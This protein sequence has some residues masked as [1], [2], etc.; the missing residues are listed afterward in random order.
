MSEHLHKRRVRAVTTTCRPWEAFSL[1]SISH[2]TC[3]AW[4]LRSIS[5]RPPALQ[6]SGRELVNR[7]LWRGEMADVD[8]W[9]SETKCRR[10]EESAVSL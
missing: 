1:L 9:R 8:L 7:V 3:K 2:H 5:C 6:V 10:L 4:G